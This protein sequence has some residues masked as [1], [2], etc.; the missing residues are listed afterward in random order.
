MARLRSYGR[1]ELLRMK[2]TLQTPNDENCSE[3]T[4]I[5][6]FMSDKTILS[7]YQARLRPTTFSPARLH[8]GGWKRTGKYNDLEVIKSRLIER[9]FTEV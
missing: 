6:A 9:G 1:T 2:L 4:Q 7:K 3:R 8:D 5:Y